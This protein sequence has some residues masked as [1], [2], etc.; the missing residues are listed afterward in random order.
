MR[1]ERAAGVFWCAHSLAGLIGGRGFEVF[2]DKSYK[3]NCHITHT[4][5]P[6]IIAP[7]VLSYDVCGS[8]AV[9]DIP[10]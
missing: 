10:W 2:R 9:D 4:T 7:A 5:N 8:S 3:I 6:V 1:Q